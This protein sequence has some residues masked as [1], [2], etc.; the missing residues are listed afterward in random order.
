MPFTSQ[1]QWRAC[2][3]QQRR[4]LQAGRV[5][6]WLCD[7]WV[8]ESPPYHELPPRSPR[9]GNFASGTQQVVNTINRAGMQVENAVN[10][11]FDKV[12]PRVQVPTVPLPGLRP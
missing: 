12:L 1:A 7:E 9:G 3:A 11:A 6:E 2:Y 5:P 4:D 8:A 10:R